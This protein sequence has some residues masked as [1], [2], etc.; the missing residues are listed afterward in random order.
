[1]ASGDEM[2]VI[3]KFTCQPNDSYEMFLSGLPEA[4]A[5]KCE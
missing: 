3:E 2:A 4:L 1:V 5:C